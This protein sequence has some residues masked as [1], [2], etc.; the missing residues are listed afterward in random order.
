MPG[1]AKSGAVALPAE[2]RD[3]VSF[4]AHDFWTE[5]PAKNADIYHAKVDFLQLTGQR[6]YENSEA[7]DSHIEG[8]VASLS[9]NAAKSFSNAKERDTGEWSTIFAKADPDSK[10]L[11]VELRMLPGSRT[12]IIQVEWQPIEWSG[13]L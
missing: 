10:F 8:R 9:I 4:M 6:F 5:Q 1:T 12:A 7:I 11:G 3:R 2:L 13:G